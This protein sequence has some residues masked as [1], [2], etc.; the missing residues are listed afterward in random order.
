MKLDCPHIIQM[1]PERV[2]NMLE[3]PHT[4]LVVVTTT[5]KHTA[6]GV[7]IHS[8]DRAIV[9]FKTVQQRSDSVVP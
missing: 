4:D 5:C 9:F 1:P 6:C 2:K 3:V 7:E 8:S